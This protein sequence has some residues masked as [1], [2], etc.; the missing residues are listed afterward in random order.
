MIMK[1]TIDTKILEREGLSMGEFLIMLFSLYHADYTKCFNGLVERGLI[2]SNLFSSSSAVLSDNSKNLVFRI[3]VESSDK[4]TN[5]S[6]QNFEYLAK[7][8]QEIY[9][10]GNKP[11]TSYPWRATIEEI[12]YKLRV[13]V[14]LC[15]FT[16]TEEEAIEATK[17]YVNSFSDQKRMSILRNFIL[18]ITRDEKGQKDIS[19]QFMTIIEKNRLEV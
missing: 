9:P 11:G 19:S 14:V 10:E 4:L 3:L 12:A 7:T 16:F 5:C 2:E 13:L 1:I 15:D 8:L 6:I 18:R 17:E